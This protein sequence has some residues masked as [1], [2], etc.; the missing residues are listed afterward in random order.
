M[1]LY[2]SKIGKGQ[3][4][5]P[6]LCQLYRHTFV[7]CRRDRKRRPAASSSSRFDLED[8]ESSDDVSKGLIGRYW[9]DTPTTASE[10]S[11]TYRSVH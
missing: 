8:G 11:I 10:A 4:R 3:P 7:H 2:F 1:Y 6:P 5:G 9:P